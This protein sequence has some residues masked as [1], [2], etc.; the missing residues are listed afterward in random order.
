MNWRYE[1]V[2]MD[3]PPEG[4]LRNAPASPR[5]GRCWAG[6]AFRM[7]IKDTS[8]INYFVIDSSNWLLEC[9]WHKSSVCA[10][11][12]DIRDS[13]AIVLDH[14]RNM[15]DSRFSQQIGRQKENDCGQ[16]E[17]VSAGQLTSTIKSLY[18][19][20]NCRKTPKPSILPRIMTCK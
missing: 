11:K 15:R 13:D 9:V 10:H 16:Y 20:R 17:R 8:L 4:R 7:R 19:I 1:T 14:S 5:G 3:L 18:I 12:S 2:K 6:N